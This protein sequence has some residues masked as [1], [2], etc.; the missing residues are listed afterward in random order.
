MVNEDDHR[1]FILT[2]LGKKWRDNKSELFLEKYDWEV[3]MA[4]NI[5]NPPV[6]IEPDHWILFVQH[7]LSDK[8]RVRRIHSFFELILSYF[9][10]G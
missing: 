3:S 1:K 4:Q 9:M 2:S 10:I 8:Q 6:G 5:Q 7:K